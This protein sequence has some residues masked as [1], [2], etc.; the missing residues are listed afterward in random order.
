MIHIIPIM[1]CHF[2]LFSS[3]YYLFFSYLFPLLSSRFPQLLYVAQVILYRMLVV[4]R[5][6]CCFSISPK[7]P[8]CY[9]AI[10]SVL[11]AFQ[12]VYTFLAFSNWLLSISPSVSTYAI[13]RLAS[14]HTHLILDKYHKITI[15]IVSLVVHFS[16]P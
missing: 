2:S 13:C 11:Y 4:P 6:L 12:V 3:V 5:M 14:I 7:N 15:T 16:L 10:N 8:T 1:G 9:V